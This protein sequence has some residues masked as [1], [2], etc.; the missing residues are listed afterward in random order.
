MSS[1]SF[2]GDITRFITGGTLLS[3]PHRVTLAARE[4]WCYPDRAVT[5]GIVAEGGLEVLE[6]LRKEH[7]ES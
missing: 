6:R 2:P 1:R 7:V 3:T 5:S 4:R